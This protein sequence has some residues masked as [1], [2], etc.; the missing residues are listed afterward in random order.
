[1][2]VQPSS[3][4]QAAI[5]VGR[6]DE[7]RQIAA[8]LGD[9]DCRLLTLVGPGGIGKTRLALEAM[10][11]LSN[12]AHHSV[13]LPD[14]AFPDG[15]Y[16]IPLQSLTSP[17][18]ILS[19]IADALSIPLY[20]GSNVR[21]CTFDY[22]RDKALMLIM[23]N[24][25]HLLDGAGTF[26]ELLAFAPDLKILVTSRERLNL[27]EEWVLDVPGLRFPA[28]DAAPDAETYSAM[29]LFVQHARR[30]RVGFALTDAEI[31]AVAQICRLVEG[32][33]LAIELAASWV[34]SL[35]CDAIAQ[36]IARS[37]DI[38]ETPARNVPA[39][40][41]SMRAVLDQSWMMLDESQQTTFKKLSV[42]RG[43]FT[44]EAAEEVAGASLRMLSA[45]VDKSLLLPDTGGRYRVHELLRQYGEEQLQAAPEEAEKTRDAHAAYYVRFVQSLNFKVD[46]HDQF[47]PTTEWQPNISA[48]KD[49]LDNVRA[50]WRWSIQRERWSDVGRMVNHFAA[51]F[52]HYK[53]AE[54]GVELL[55][56][57]IQALRN[58]ARN[59]ETELV[60]G[61]LLARQAAFLSFVGSPQQGKAAAEEAL[62]LLQGGAPE[63]LL[64]ALQNYGHCVLGMEAWSDIPQRERVHEEAARL[65][66][67]GYQLAQ[68]IG[69]QRQ[70][71]YFRYQQSWYALLRGNLEEARRLGEESLAGAE[72]TGNTELIGLACGMLLGRIFEALGDY[73]QARRMRLRALHIA[74]ETDDPWSI[75]GDY[76]GL[77][78]I[79]YLQGNY[80][81][82]MRCYR[83]SLRQFTHLFFSL[84]RVAHLS[85]TLVNIAKLL[86]AQDRR[87]D[88]AAL[89]TL[90]TAH[91]G[92]LQGVRSWAEEGLAT[93][94]AQLS[95]EAFARAI[96]H[97][98]TLDFETVVQALLTEESAEIST[99]PGSDLLNERELQILRLLAEGKSNREIAEAL[100][101][102]VGTV[103]WYVNQIYGKLHVGS[104]TQAAARARELGVL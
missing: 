41:R 3:V 1:M 45:F 56:A 44:R 68:E 38:L 35:S 18:L 49:D 22:L 88:A 2:N 32:M 34:R 29:Q 101:F 40:H 76:A 19:T 8:A 59:Q 51:L 85:Q 63:N 55:G 79:E 84:P 47:T 14:T 12:N 50:A 37:L 11:L 69:D 103:K 27:L 77:G 39:R 96:E 86:A 43:G 91:T 93:L 74:E 16:F 80:A 48:Y 9:P 99:T 46:E 23:D 71:P 82:A 10:R 65:A 60:L 87:E 26:S 73:A 31:P 5:F 104:R 94:Q 100:I 36:E 67:R 25:E 75:G 81:E 90:V 53:L 30:A 24:A 20:E 42:F 92:N 33:P 66:A 57:A 72:A 15:I 28:A 102:S 13:P 89:F 64:I 78:Y 83:Q 95:P 97:G 17:D 62:T 4:Q 61:I 7:L 54:E 52:S 21:Q 6:E 98:K 70:A 58:T